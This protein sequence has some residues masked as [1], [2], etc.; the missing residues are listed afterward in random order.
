MRVPSVRG[1]HEARSETTE[2]CAE[3]GFFHVVSRVWL[4]HK[5]LWQRPVVVT[6]H[7]ETSGKYSRMKQWNLTKYWGLWSSAMRTNSLHPQ[8]CQ[9][10][11]LQHSWQQ[12]KDKASKGKVESW[13]QIKHASVSC[14]ITN[15]CC[16]K[17]HIPSVNAH[18]QHGC[19]TLLEICCSY[20]CPLTFIAPTTVVVSAEL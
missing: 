11:L 14:L 8:R 13:G 17:H 2:P 1:H 19:P 10:K 3:W 15:M 4:H 5:P 16:W 6:V 9:Y 12:Q 18:F 7:H 20:Q